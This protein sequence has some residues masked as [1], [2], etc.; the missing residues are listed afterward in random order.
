MQRTSNCLLPV[1]QSFSCA[2]SRTH[3][4]IGLFQPCQS[5]YLD[6]VYGVVHNVELAVAA[7]IAGAKQLNGRLDDARYI[8]Y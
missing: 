1:S 4:N 2:A 3:T 8:E 5:V 6:T 7:D